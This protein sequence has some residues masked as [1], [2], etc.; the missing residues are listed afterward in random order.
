MNLSSFTI[1]KPQVLLFIFAIIP[2]IFFIFFRFRKVTNALQNSSKSVPVS[3][4]VKSLRFAVTLRTLF[5]CLAW[6]F[7]VLAFSGI[8]FGTKRIPVHKSGNNVTF[9]FDISYS[10]LAGDAPQKITRLDAM[11]I[12]A[13][14]LLEQLNFSSFSA[15]LAKGDG[16]VAIPETEDTAL[17]EN[18]IQNLSPS[19]VTA[20][21]T[22]LGK[23]IEAAVNA[24]PTTSSKAQ[25]IWVFTDGDETDNL[26]E[27]SIET[28]ARFAIPVSIVGFG[29]ENESEITAGDGKTRVKTALR[30]NKIKEIC[31]KLNKQTYSKLLFKNSPTVSYIDSRENSSA[32]KLLNQITT[33]SSDEEKTLS[34]ELK[35]VNRHTFFIFWA[36]FFLI[37]SFVAAEFKVSSLQKIKKLFSATAALS[38]LVFSSCTN[39]K[40]QVLEGVWA[41][42]EGKYTSA[43]ADFLNTAN[44]A[45]QDPQTQQYA[46]YD[47][48]ATYLSM[49]ELDA[50]LER[51][52]QLNLDNKELPPDLRSA[53][54]YNMGVIYEQRSDYKQAAECFK[55]SILADSRNLNAKVNLELCERELVQK[56]VKAA[57][58]LMQA[59]NEEKAD[60]SDMK[61]E[62]FNLIR[63]NES[64]KWRNMS[65]SSSKEES[66]ID[67]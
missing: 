10:M 55:K 20:T 59:V 23:G 41:W 40:K 5:L 67:Y 29:S 38:I 26:L 12:Y 13:S 54:F 50:S 39:E 37:L 11:K 36:V 57:E 34:Y 63:K 62:L 25:Y 15:V 47:L 46:I 4:L 24:I 17:M 43:T 31:E 22:S 61:T 14:S 1:E 3:P 52:N 49:N 19:L 60:K 33:K 44:K 48:S 18:L 8:S 58:S 6:I 30:S 53:A 45:R 7:A 27:K 51:L 56:Q 9:V 16:F 28:A 42:Y 32:W 64:K 66:G 2:A 65:E 35:T 21:G